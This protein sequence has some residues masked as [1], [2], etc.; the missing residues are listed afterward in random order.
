M[1]DDVIKSKKDLLNAIPRPHVE[2]VF[3]RAWNKHIYMRQFTVKQK[4]AWD[5]EL[6]NSPPDKRLINYR[7]KLAVNTICDEK[8]ELLLDESDML[9]ISKGANPG[10]D[11]IFENAMRINSIS[12]DELEE[13]AKN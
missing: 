4:D 5:Q 11:E 10:F 6:E 7:I 12:K 2:K 3:I 8:G 1:T 13:Q 9:E